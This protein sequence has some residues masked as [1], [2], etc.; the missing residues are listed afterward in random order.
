M[1]RSIISRNGQSPHTG[2]YVTAIAAAG[3][4]GA[5][6][7]DVVE[8]A[9]DEPTLDRWMYPFNQCPGCK[10]FASIFAA[11]T[12]EGF[13]REFDNRDSQM[14]IGFDTS[15]VIP[16][17]LGRDSYFI[18]SA[19]VTL[20]VL[21]DQTFG[22]DPTVD[23]YTSWLDPNDPNYEPDPDPGRPVELF[24]ANFRYGWTAVTFPEDGPF[25][26]GCNCFEY[27]KYVRSVYPIDFDDNGEPR[28]VSNNFD[29]QFDPVPFA[30]GLNDGLNP[31]D[32]VPL[33]TELTYE[34]NISD[35]FIQAYLQ[36]ALDQGMLDLVIASIFPAE[37]QQGGTFPKFYTKEN[38][39]VWKF[40]LVDAA[41]LALTVDVG[42]PG[43]INGDGVV[44][45]ADFLILLGD[46][47]PCADCND[48]PADI[49]G[50]CAVGVSDL[51]ILLGNWG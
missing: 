4:V 29:E 30:I 42:I 18:L 35:P 45:V 48:C 25:C 8:V 36:E 21:S 34:I 2:F 11:L 5:S 13:V 46:W 7:A 22:Y 10:H 19:T 26:E 40:G 24:G 50:N 14:L 47:G 32:P 49:D 23:P 44:G 1:G 39:L 3:L 43:D 51:L 6:H 12:K 41:Q 38:V 31:G 17:D 28:N 20:T 15:A 27:C 37:F 16:T 9:F 33:D